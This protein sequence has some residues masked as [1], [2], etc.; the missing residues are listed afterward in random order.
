MDR[1]TDFELEFKDLELELKDLEEVEFKDLEEWCYSIGMAYARSIM[2]Q[3]LTVLDEMLLKARDK[4]VYRAKDKR[5]RTLKTLMGEVEMLRR[6][7]KTKNEKGDNCYIYLLDQIIGLDTVGKISVN[8]IRRM[9][10]IICE[11]PYRSTASAVSFLS[12][13]NISHSGVWNAV[14]KAGKAIDEIDE[15]RGKSIEKSE[16]TGTKVVKVLQEEFDGVWVNIQGD[17]R[18]K[19]GR[20]LEMKLASS[21][22]GVKFTG[23]DKRGKPTYDMENPLFMAGFDEASDFFWK[24]EGQIASIY[25]I[26]EIEMR[27]IN[28]DGGGWVKGFGDKSGINAHAQLDQFHIKKELRRSGI[29]KEKQQRIEKL[30]SEKKIRVMLRYVRMLKHYEEDEK[31]REQLGRMLKYFTNSAKIMVP[32]RERGI[33]IPAPPEG[34]VYGNMGT[35]EGTV[36]NLVA[37]RMKR[38]KASFSKDGAT[39]LARLI[40]LKRSGKLDGVI[41]EMNSIAISKPLERIIT[42]GLSAAQIPL[43]T[44]D[45]Y[46]YPVNGAVPF[47]EG[48][49]T[50]G[51]KAVKGMVN[52]RSLAEMSYK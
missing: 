51:R 35:M 50:N 32:I 27:L 18:P 33:E 15:A 42:E 41:S 4:S 26:G 25:D 12:G 9:A 22:E 31:K 24:K 19:K 48:F 39:K 8:L 16:Y 49:M 44:G 7:Y 34:L 38:R 6:L 47:T 20:K 5:P 46:H 36:C 3:I 13:Q 2:C 43:K 11:S 10:E 45:G 1:L 17:D 40:C 52:Y 23:N 14:M 21:Y 30:I 29:E 37:L 28:G